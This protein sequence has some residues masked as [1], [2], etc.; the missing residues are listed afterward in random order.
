M[1]RSLKLVFCDSGMQADAL[2]RRCPA[3]RPQAGEIVF[4]QVSQD[5]LDHRRVFDAGDDLDRAPQF[6]QVSTSIC[7]TRNPPDFPPARREVFPGAG[8]VAFRD[9]ASRRRSHDYG[10]DLRPSET[11]QTQCLGMPQQSGW[12]IR[13]VQGASP[14]ASPSVAQSVCGHRFGLALW[15]SHPGPGGL[16]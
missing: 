9:R 14:I 2:G 10:E 4:S 12:G 8:A 5:S 3:F 1:E 16:A 13:R 6:G 7:K 11:S 15:A